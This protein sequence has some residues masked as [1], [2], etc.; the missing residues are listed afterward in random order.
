MKKITITILVTLVT[1]IPNLFFAQAAFD[2]F[3]G[4]DDVTTV[5]VSKK[6]FEM[7]GKVKMNKNDRKAQQYLNLLKKLDNL[8]VFV[9]TNG[10]VAGD[11]KSTVGRYLTTSPLE[12]LIRV[13]ERDKNVKI[14]V[15]SGISDSQIKELLMF[16][17]GGIE[18]ETI[19]MSLT[20]NFDINEISVL[21]NKMN[22]PGGDELRKISK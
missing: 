12:Q 9:T 17:E 11:M 2:K 19:L 8:K 3:D 5:V 21:T 15:K 14:Y 20:G 4:E 16:I 1:I 13:N 18:N 10:K 22:I 6:M 7:M